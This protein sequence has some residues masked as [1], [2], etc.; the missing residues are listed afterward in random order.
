MADFLT[1]LVARSQERGPRLQRRVPSLFE[2]AAGDAFGPGDIEAAPAHDVVGESPPPAP[3]RAALHDAGTARDPGRES[4]AAEP[5][6]PAAAPVLHRQR[7][8]EP[9][10][11]DVAHVV[12]RSPALPAPTARAEEVRTPDVVGTRAAPQSTA[13]RPQPGAVAGE[14]AARARPALERVRIE[15]ELLRETLVD[16]TVV[17]PPSRWR[18]AQPVVSAG[19]AR[20]IVAAARTR[21]A[22]ARTAGRRQ[23]S[24]AAP[25]QEPSPPTI[26]VTIGRVEVRASRPA[27]APKR[28]RHES[29][30][31]L[32]LEDYLRRR[33]GRPDE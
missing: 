25:A 9:I 33:S 28:G 11:I 19:A 32:S 13:S 23:P 26:S 16:Q 5:A 18:P 8:V 22:V 2:P 14:P 10:V 29:E 7:A 6:P 12:R 21:E 27:G 17:A 20:A 1:H 24:L 4:T 30:P 3:R 15:R 31:R